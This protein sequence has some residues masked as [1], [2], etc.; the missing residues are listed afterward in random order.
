VSD[1]AREQIQKHLVTGDN[2]LKQGVSPDKTR[3]SYEAALRLAEADAAL[4]R[5]DDKRLANIHQT[6]SE[7]IEDIGAHEQPG[8]K[9]ET[10]DESS[11]KTNVIGIDTRKLISGVFCIPGLGRLDDCAAL[12]LADFLKRRGVFARTAAVT[13]EIEAN[14]VKTLC[15]C[16]LEAIS[17]ARVD[18]TVRKF[19]R[20]A[21]AAKILVCQFGN[22]L[23]EGSSDKVANDGALR[24]LEAVLL[25]IE[26]N[27]LKPSRKER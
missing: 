14:T 23:E 12:L 2:R 16:Y 15:V 10:E 3:E 11:E 25:E 13:T 4:G 8:K 9:K 17:S 20:Q 24:S 7:I 5:L 18:F 27:V 22:P 19:S 21:P 1:S 6:V 26:K